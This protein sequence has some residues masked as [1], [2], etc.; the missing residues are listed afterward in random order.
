MRVVDDHF[1]RDSIFWKNRFFFGSWKFDSMTKARYLPLRSFERE[2]YIVS[3]LFE[4]FSLVKYVWDLSRR[5]IQNLKKFQSWSEKNLT[6]LIFL[7]LRDFFEI[8]QK[9]RCVNVEIIGMIVFF[10]R[11]FNS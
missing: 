5:W 6:R 3:S 1:I 11:L 7:Q 9:N 2:R 10:A 4:F 8:T